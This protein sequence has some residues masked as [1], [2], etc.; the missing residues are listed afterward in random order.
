MTGMSSGGCESAQFRRIPHEMTEAIVRRGEW[1]LCAMEH[2]RIEPAH[3]EAAGVPFH[4]LAL[5]LEH[6]PL[7]FGL[8]AEG[9]RQQFGRNAPDMI[10]MMEAGAGSTSSWDATFESACFYF[11]TESLA[12]ALGFDIDDTAHGVRTRVEMYAPTI[13]RLLQALH[14]DAASGQPH[15]S[16]IG[17]AIFVALAAEL[18]PSGEHRRAVGRSITEPWRVRRALTYIHARLTDKLTIATIAIN[19]A[20]SPFY[21]NHGFRAAL[22]CSIWQYVVSAR[23]RY[24]LVLMRDP[25]LNLT[26][27]ALSSGFETYASFIAAMQRE[28]GA[29]PASLQRALDNR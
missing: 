22:G 10:T 25:R 15:G 4:H 20:T 5:P 27:V 23:A 29:A 1:S 24:A 13:V 8:K 2:S 17:D 18:V 21:L 3:I 12:L 6:V 7:K 14:A 28:Y 26:G 9:H 11:T 19:A 16:L